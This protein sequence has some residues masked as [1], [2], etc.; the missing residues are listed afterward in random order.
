MA[1]RFFITGLPRSRTAWLAVA[2]SRSNAI[3]HHEP[4][5]WLKDHEALEELWAPSVVSIGVSDSA[6]GVA[7]G[8]ILEAFGP[9]TLIVQRPIEDV[10]TSIAGYLGKGGFE[11]NH[12]RLRRR[13]LFINDKLHKHHRHPLVRVVAYEDLT[14]VETVRNV[15]GWLTPS[16]RPPI[17]LDQLMHLNIQADLGYSV[18]VAAAAKLWWMP[19]ELA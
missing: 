18:A 10:L 4:S 9:R 14:N 8:P 6:L 2:L 11:V 7:I 17:D 3:C 16:V 12:E 19:A 1:N 15:I 5:A 13:L